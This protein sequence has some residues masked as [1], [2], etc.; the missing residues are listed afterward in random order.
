MTAPQD[1]FYPASP[2]EI[3]DAM[4]HVLKWA[5]VSTKAEAYW[6]SPGDGSPAVP[7]PRYPDPLSA[8]AV[9]S[10]WVST[11]VNRKDFLAALA[12]VRGGA[13]VQPPRESDSSSTGA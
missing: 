4:L 3:R 10:F 13:P 9:R 12:K 2:I 6:L 8:V 11:G 7:L 1:E 5:P